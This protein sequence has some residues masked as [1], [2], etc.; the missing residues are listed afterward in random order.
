MHENDERVIVNFLIF[1]MHLVKHVINICKAFVITKKNN[2]KFL[3]N[4]WYKT[5]SPV[6]FKQ[7]IK[8]NTNNSIFSPGN[9]QIKMHDQT[10]SHISQIHFR[11]HTFSRLRYISYYCV[12]VTKSIYTFACV[13]QSNFD[14]RRHIDENKLSIRL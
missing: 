6:N 13:S 12:N 9:Q 8:T 4:I 14:N 7:A 2:F 5:N 3:R 1:V 11:L 10:F